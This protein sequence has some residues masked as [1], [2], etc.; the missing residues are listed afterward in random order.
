MEGQPYSC[1]ILLDALHF[2]EG[3][4]NTF[5]T[6]CGMLTP[7][8]FDVSAITGL[9][10]HGR[11]FNSEDTAPVPLE[12]KVDDSGKPTYN[13]F[14]DHHAKTSGPITKEEHVAFLTF[15][16]SR[17]IFCS[18]SMQVAKQFS[19][20]VTQLHRGVRIA[21]GPLLLSNLYTCLTDIS[22]QMT[23]FD[24]N[25]PKKK[26]ILAYGPFWLLQQ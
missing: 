18:R 1:G 7:T 19:F 3:S 6:I 21:L 10:P 20:L 25:N 9:R 22:T 4:T 24:P 5:H 16:L 13:K 15:W 8:L 26:N 17:Y 12:F 14:I 2:W 23:A 11:S